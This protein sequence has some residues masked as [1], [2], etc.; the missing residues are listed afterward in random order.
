M[1]E[2]R[3]QRTEEGVELKL[4]QH[5]DLDE[6]S[7]NGKKSIVNSILLKGKEDLVLCDK[8]LGVE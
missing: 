7:C 8:R 1:R 6:V 4:I 3:E 2:D 5:F